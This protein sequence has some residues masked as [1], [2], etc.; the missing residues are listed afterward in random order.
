MAPL[1]FSKLLAGFGEFSIPALS[2]IIITFP[3]W[4]SPFHPAIVAYFI[5]AFDLYF[6][7][8]SI[9]TSFYAAV[10]YRQILLYRSVRFFE[11]LKLNDAA[12]TIKHCVIIP[13]YMEP[14]E[15]LASTVEMM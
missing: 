15:K 3:I 6:L 2:W 5:I 13:N 14:L 9:T 7:Y 4:F 10:S 1:R 8:K 12:H 11:K